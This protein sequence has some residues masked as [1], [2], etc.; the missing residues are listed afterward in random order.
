MH[1]TVNSIIY[2]ILIHLFMLS[3]PKKIVIEIYSVRNNIRLLVFNQSDII[4]MSLAHM[5]P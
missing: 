4:F 5:L 2:D 3:F 1:K